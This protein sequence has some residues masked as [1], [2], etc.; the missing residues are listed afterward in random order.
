MTPAQQLAHRFREVLLNGTFIANTNYRHQLEGTSWQLAVAPPPMQL[1]SIALLTQHIHYYIAGVLQVLRGGSL[2]I[3]D[4]YSFDFAP[5]TSQ[6]QWDDIL[7][8]LWADAEAFAQLVAL[9]N[10]DDLE[11]PFTD[12]KYGSYQRNIDA[13]IEHCYYHLG[14]VTLLKKMLSLQS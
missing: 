10:P 11:A 3:K 7:H 4:Q 12:V 8:R 6:Q 1:N 9:L 5:I 14:Q 13:M 2:D